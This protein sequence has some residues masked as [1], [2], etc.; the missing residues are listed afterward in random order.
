MIGPMNNTRLLGVLALI[1]APMC[2]ADSQAP[3]ACNLRAF[4]PEQRQRWRVLLD[5]VYAAVSDRRELPNGYAFLIDT[6]RMPLRQLAEWID[7]ERR[8]C[9]FFNFE[10]AVQGEDGTTWLSLKGRPGVK[11]FIEADM[12][13]LRGQHR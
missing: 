9:P 11:A 5:G 13:A 12:P 10:L 1:T 2:I 7:L 8:C 4:Q 6:N 3:F